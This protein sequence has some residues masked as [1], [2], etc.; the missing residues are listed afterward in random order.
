MDN[1]EAIWRIRDHMIVHSFNEE[2]AILITEALNMAIKALEQQSC[3]D[4]VSSEPRKIDEWDI[5]GKTAELWIVKGKL[6]IRYLGTIHNTDLHSVQPKSPWIHIEFNGDALNCPLPDDGERV[7]LRFKNGY[8]TTDTCQV[9]ID[10]EDNTCYG[11]E[12]NPDF[13]DIDAWMKIPE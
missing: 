13:E 5:N 2:R 3:E 8:V 7:F 1:K 12:D 6:Q 11:F 10:E 9:T 4:A